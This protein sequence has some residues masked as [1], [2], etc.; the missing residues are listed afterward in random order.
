MDKYMGNMSQ[1]VAVQPELYRQ[2]LMLVLLSRLVLA[3]LFGIVYICI[4]L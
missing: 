3:A 2:S 4:S 1:S